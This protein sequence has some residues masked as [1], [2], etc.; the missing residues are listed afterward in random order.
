MSW[1]SLSALVSFVLFGMGLM[2]FV[3]GRRAYLDNRKSKSGK[4]MYGLCIS[5]FIWNLGYAWMG[6][7]HSDDFAYIPRAISLFSIIIYMILLLNYVTYLTQ[8][9]KKVLGPYFV[10]FFITSILYWPFLIGKNTVTFMETPWG[11][12]Y[13]SSMSWARV[14]QFISTISA[15]I[16]FYVIIHYGKK[17]TQLKRQIYIYNKFRWFGVILFAGYSL[18]TL[19]PSLFH[20]AAIPGSSIAAFFSTLLLFSISRSNRAFG[21][22]RDNVAEYV[23]RDVKTPVLVL[24]WQGEIVLFNDMT[25][26]ILNYTEDELIG[27]SMDDLFL[28]IPKEQHNSLSNILQLSEDEELRILRK[29]QTICK[30]S[31]TTVKDKFDELLYS[32]IFVQDMSDVQKAFELMNESR[33]AAEDASHAKSNFLANMSHEIR[34]PMNAIIG[35]SDIILQNPKIPAQTSAQIQDIKTAGTSLLGIINDILDI[36]KIEAGKY[37]LIDDEYDL[38]SLL[39]DTSNI[40]GVKIME[41]KVAFEIDIDPTMPSLLIGDATRVRQILMNILGN[42]VKFTNSGRIALKASWNH[43]KSNPY[44]YF[45]VSDTGIGMKEEDL[46]GIFGA[47]NQVDTRRN[48]NIQGTGLGLA[49]SKQLAQMMDGDITVES[50]YGEGSTFHISIHQQINDYIEIGS[51]VAK[52]IVEK[53]YSYIERHNPVVFTQRPD[54]KVLVVDDNRINLTVAK[55]FLKPYGM[56]VDTALSGRIAIDMVQEK[57]YDIVFMDHMMPELDGIDT[58]KMIR[59]LEGRKYKDLIIIALT[60][61]AISDAKEMF[62]KNGLQ[63]FLAKPIEKKELNRLLDKWL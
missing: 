46:D 24:N 47:F 53:R 7:C 8:F 11:Y 15:I 25:T 51:E 58:T 39:H 34:T 42:A 60:A 3:F 19:I 49:I 9:P 29:N 45:D 26:E 13:T 59:Q 30:L 5:V 32:I 44:L 2:A 62:L 21:V 1:Y 36:S 28:K 18:D 22:S 38:P 37:E 56:E 57:D 17:N 14:L 12:W 41:S 40:I 35:M 31:I 63:D 55:G 33:Q 61:N 54:C 43:D 23:F 16:L 10:G 50:V 48:R 27:Q 6:L 52:S 4:L 20:T